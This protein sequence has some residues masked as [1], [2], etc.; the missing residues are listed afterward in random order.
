MILINS[1]LLSEDYKTMSV[2]LT[3]DPASDK[4][5]LALFIQVGSCYL[6]G[7]PGVDVSSR[8]V[9]QVG[10]DIVTAEI[11]ISDISSA[12]GSIN[13]SCGYNK[14]IFDGIF[15]VQAT[16]VVAAVE[17]ADEKPLLNAY[18][19]SLVLAHRILAIDTPDKLNETNLVYLLLK[20]AVSYTMLEKTEQ[21][22]AA[23]QRVEA[24]N[25]SVPQEFYS[26][27]LAPCGIGTGCWIVDGVYVK[28]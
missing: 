2:V 19:Q 15:S 8:L 13:Y 28:F 21:A 3:T 27:E 26:P 11:P 5:A 16:D 22:L 20:A 12:D 24:L 17:Q 9:T 6:N 10:S 4:S 7:D 23:Y 14:T 1:V 18:Y 25:E